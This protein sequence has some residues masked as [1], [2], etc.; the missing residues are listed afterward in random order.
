MKME[1]TVSAQSAGAVRAILCKP[2]RTVATGDPL[3]VLEAV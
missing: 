1:V 2:G 3:I